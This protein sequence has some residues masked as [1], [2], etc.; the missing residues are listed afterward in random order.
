[1]MGEIEPLF[2]RFF[3]G[4]CRDVSFSEPRKVS[5]LWRIQIRNVSIRIISLTSTGKD[6]GEEGEQEES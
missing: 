1:M 3:H 2:H 5:K 6:K 4:W